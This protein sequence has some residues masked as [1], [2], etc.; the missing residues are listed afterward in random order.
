VTRPAHLLAA[1]ALL[2]AA[3]LAPPPQARAAQA[4]PVE[5]G[6][7]SIS[8]T[9]Q[10][11]DQLMPWIKGAELSVTGNA[12][13]AD[14]HK[15]I[16]TA[17]LIK[18]ANLIE[19]RKFG[20]YP[21]Y[22]ARAV[23]VDYDLNLA[24]LTV[25]DPQFWQGLQPLPLAKEPIRSGL[26]S[27]NRWRSNGRMEQGTGEVADFL[28]SNSPYGLLEYPIMRGTTTMGGLGWCEVLTREGAVIGVITGHNNQQVQAIGS[29]LLRLLVVA[30]E[31]KGNLHFAHRGFAWQRLNQT[32]LR[33]S[34]GLDG[35][36]T[37]VLV[38]RIF[39]GGT[40]S[41]ELHPMDILHKI[42]GYAIDPEGRIVHPAYGPLLFTMAI[43][44]SLGPTIPVEIQRDG[45]RLRLELQR[46]RFKPLD[47]RIP[48]PQFDRPNDY[49][50]F[51]GLV[52][53]ELTVGYL[54]A[55][56]REWRDKAP[57]RLVIEY[58]MH[59]LRDPEDSPE[60]VVIISRVLPDPSN[61]G[62]EDVGNAIVLKAN[63][64]PLRSLQDFREAIRHPQGAYDVIELLPGSG[65]VKLVYDAAQL[66]AINARVRE[67]YGIPQPPARS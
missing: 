25:D 57:A 26:F 58:A 65:R 60:R 14:G 45:K 67:R 16:T 1:L 12:V 18:N 63:G 39:S 13:V 35:S 59:S 5:A 64:K 48:P 37:G 4:D 2:A 46:L 32:D 20:R 9:S 55:W 54:Q 7:V 8:V 49:E 51:G 23:L 24:L 28:V 66:P 50:V 61:L 34:L 42:N 21:D 44:E 47:Y 17:D 53:Q 11:F 40:G 29:D 52:L 56:G 43:N 10:P 19:V 38:R 36:D 15:L 27:I 3:L 41:R 31:S 30:S 62:Y 22:P 33:A 6:I